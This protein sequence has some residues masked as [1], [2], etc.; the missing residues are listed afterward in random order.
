MLYAH[1]GIRAIVG[2]WLGGVLAKNGAEGGNRTLTPRE[3]DRILSVPQ[4][5]LRAY[6]DTLTA[7]PLASLPRCPTLPL[8]ANLLAATGKVVMPLAH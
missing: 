5:R 8:L 6:G 4:A 3:R 7:P 2:R 1:R